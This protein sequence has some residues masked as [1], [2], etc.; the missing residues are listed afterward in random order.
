MD[1]QKTVI[2]FMKEAMEA[3]ERLLEKL[4]GEEIEA[5]CSRS[6]EEIRRVFLSDH[7]VIKRD[8]KQAI[9]AYLTARAVRAAVALKENLPKINVLAMEPWHL[10]DTMLRF[11]MCYQEFIAMGTRSSKDY[12]EMMHSHVAGSIVKKNR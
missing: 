8:E 7:E 2:D 9:K 5:Y 11:G 3:A 6:P 1:Y 4:P 12:Q 10:A